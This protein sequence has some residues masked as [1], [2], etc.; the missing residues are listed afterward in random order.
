VKIIYT[1]HCFT[2]CIGC[3]L[4]WQLICSWHLLLLL[5]LSCSSYVARC[6]CW[7]PTT[8]RFRTPPTCLTHPTCCT[9][10]TC[11][12]RTFGVPSGAAPPLSGSPVSGSWWGWQRRLTGWVGGWAS[13]SSLGGWVGGYLTGWVG[14]TGGLL[15]GWVGIIVLSGQWDECC[16]PTAALMC[17]FV[18]TGTRCC[19]S[20]WQPAFTSLPAGA[21]VMRNCNNNQ[22]QPMWLGMVVMP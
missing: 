11:S 8:C 3:W 6:S 14:I 7:T 21:E 4:N 5:A 19:C 18:C 2:H 20:C 15:G 13:L 16:C 17:H 22:K 1:V 10:E 12:G 9:M